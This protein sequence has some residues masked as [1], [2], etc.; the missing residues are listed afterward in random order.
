MTDHLVEKVLQTEPA[1][2]GHLVKLYVDTVQLPDGGQ[3]KREIVRHPGAVAMVPLLDDGRVVLVRQYR[4]AAG[5]VL[6]EIPAGT[7]EPGEDPLRAAERELQEETG[8]KPGSL[9]RL[10]HEYAAPGYTTELIHLFLATELVP[11]ALDQDADEFIEV[12]TLP[13]EE[14]VAQVMRGEIEDSKTMLALLLVA[15]RL[16]R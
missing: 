2:E 6:V 12:V 9:E 5:K 3:S 16:G 10:G 8:Y 14:A 1:Y 11:S 13:F 15:R 4:H 7:L